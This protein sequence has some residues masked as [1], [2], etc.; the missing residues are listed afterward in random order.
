MSGKRRWKRAERAKV[1]QP[2]SGPT[3]Q[4]IN[5]A[6]FVF[7][8]VFTVIFISFIA[9]VLIDALDSDQPLHESTLT[10]PYGPLR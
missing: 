10:F 5:T 1:E 6:A 7:V 4:K 2:L 9:I 3:K 8:V